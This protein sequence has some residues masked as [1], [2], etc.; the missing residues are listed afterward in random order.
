MAMAM[1]QGQE[2]LHRPSSKF[3]PDPHRPVALDPTG[4][5]IDVASSLFEGGIVGSSSLTVPS[6]TVY[7]FL[8]CCSLSLPVRG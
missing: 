3:M 6:L 8:V 7:S 4:F 2:S 1:V 5:V